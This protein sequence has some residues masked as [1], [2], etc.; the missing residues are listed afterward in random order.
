VLQD[1]S[2]TDVAEAIVAYQD[3]EPSG[4]KWSDFLL[5]IPAN[6]IDPG[7]SYGLSA[8]ITDSQDRLLQTT[9]RVQPLS[10]NAP[11]AVE[12]V[13]RRPDRLPSAPSAARTRTLNFDCQGLT[14]TVHVEKDRARL[15]LPDRTLVLDRVQ[16]EAE[17]EYGQAGAKLRIVGDALFL[18]LA[19][20]VYRD[21]EPR[22]P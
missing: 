19:G 18:E 22:A 3:T 12:L 10:P 9:D 13:V 7:R 8:R 11:G 4:R 21:C 2:R 16:G 15:V 17:Q 14:V 1:L 5:Q 6:L 20:K